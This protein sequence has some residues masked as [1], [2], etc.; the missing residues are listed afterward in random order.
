MALA[1]R[2]TTLERLVDFLPTSQSRL[3]GEDRERAVMCIDAATIAIEQHLQRPVV[4]REFEERHDAGFSGRAG[5]LGQIHRSGA[6]KLF[7]KRYPI[8]S[9]A[10]IEDD[11][12]NTVDADAYWI[13]PQR[14]Y[15]QYRGGGLEGAV[16]Y[17][18]AGWPAPVGAWTVTYSAGLAAN[19]DAVETA[20]PDIELACLMATRDLW[21][22]GPPAL[23]SKS[24][25]QKG[26]SYRAPMSALSDEVK[27]LLEP[28]I[29]RTY[30]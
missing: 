21:R 7:L 14:G 12:S 8:V 20:A 19:T 23:T 1:H 26:E 30:C 22:G 6:N 25:G 10:S 28:Y 15:L 16:P 18:G 2:I 17:N 11:N 29:A 4:I 5:S 13:D 24:S 9:V 27:S 3:E